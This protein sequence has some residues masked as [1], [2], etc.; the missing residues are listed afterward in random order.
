M[1]NTYSEI[2]IGRLTFKTI[3]DYADIPM[4]RLLDGTISFDYA[5]PKTAE[6]YVTTGLLLGYPLESTAA[7]LSG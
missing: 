2:G 5:N 1:E 6:Q 3:R 7:L 4:I